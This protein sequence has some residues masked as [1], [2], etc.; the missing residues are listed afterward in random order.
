MYGRGVDCIGGV[1]KASA[2][3]ADLNI[4]MAKNCLTASYILYM[5]FR[6]CG[7]QKLILSWLGLAPFE[8]S[9]PQLYDT[10]Q[11]THANV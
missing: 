3:A 1:S 10:V 8:T 11:S 9:F 4:N 5:S 7:G 2:Y 6:Y